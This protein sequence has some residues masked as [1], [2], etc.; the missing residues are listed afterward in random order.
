VTL[1]SLENIT[2]RF[3]EIVAINQL[4]LTVEDGEYICILGPT[5]AG[6][7]TLLR[8]I[9]GLVKTDT[10]KIIINDEVVNDKP[11]EE[12]DTLYMFQQYAL[13]PHMN[14]WEN[15]SYGPTIKNWQN[16][17]IEQLTREILDMV[18]LAIGGP[19]SPPR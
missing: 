2:K 12:R 9:A 14:V 8:S 6:K 17:R 3:D 19:N 18:H 11:P 13:F 16:E 7:T 5:G 1:I 10:G 15:V 4:S